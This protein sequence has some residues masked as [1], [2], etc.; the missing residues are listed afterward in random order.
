MTKLLGAEHIEELK[1]EIKN[2]SQNLSEVLDKLIKSIDEFN[3][4]TSK[5]ANTQKKLQIWLCIFTFALVIVGAL[6]VFFR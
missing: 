6:Q 3:A 2:S 1:D 5:F 4:S